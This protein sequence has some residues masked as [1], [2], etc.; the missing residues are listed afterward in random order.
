MLRLVRS[1]ITST[2]LSRTKERDVETNDVRTV[3]E[4]LAEGVEVKE[5]REREREEAE[6][7]REEDEERRRAR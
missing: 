4:T 5:Q 3:G 6:V 7:D 2:G 1:Q